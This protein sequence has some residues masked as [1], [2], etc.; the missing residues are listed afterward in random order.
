MQMDYVN[1]VILIL[2]DRLR[3]E[4]NLVADNAPKGS[5]FIVAE[6]VGFSQQYIQQIRKGIS[7]T[8]ETLEN[9][10]LMLKLILEYRKL[11]NKE[12]TKLQKQI[13]KIDTDNV[14]PDTPKG[15]TYKAPPPGSAERQARWVDIQT[16]KASGKEVTK[17]SPVVGSFFSQFT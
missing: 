7:L 8:T 6:K 16:D 3:Q 4:L 1:N 10:R 2:M 12:I 5:H 14:P 11:I 15:Y 13:K 17:G 9:E